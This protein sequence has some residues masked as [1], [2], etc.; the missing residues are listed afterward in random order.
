MKRED[1]KTGGAEAM[2]LISS[3]MTQSPISVPLDATVRQAIDIMIDNAVRHLPVTNSGALSGIV[4]ESDVAFADN[5]IE[6]GL[7]NRLRVRDICCLDV[8][9]VAPDTPLD[10]VLAEMAARRIGSVI[11]TQGD[12]IAGLF[13]AT[14]A[15]R[16]FAEHLRAKP[17]A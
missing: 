1:T 7:A 4:S 10:E 16:C 17:G 11:I 13:T 2:P 3:V 15:C 14:D 12:A 8:Y 9:T 5:A 6:P